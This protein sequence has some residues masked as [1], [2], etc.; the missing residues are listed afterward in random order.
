MGTW[1]RE[2]YPAHWE[3]LALAAK[4]RTHWKCQRC[5]VAHGQMAVNQHGS[6]YVVRLAACHRDGDTWNPDAVLLALCQAC[7]LRLDAMQ[8][9][10]T[11]R[12]NERERQVHAGQM[13]L[14]AR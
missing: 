12:R 10:R 6:L 3:E 1:R 8:H 14:T 7:H 2:Q 4:A 13:E 11:R 9:W 5:G